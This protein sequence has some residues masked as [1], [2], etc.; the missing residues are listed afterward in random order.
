[1]L[2]FGILINHRF[3]SL[4]MD[5]TEKVKAFIDKKH[6]ESGGSCGTY[7]PDI[8]IETELEYDVLKPIL[9]Q[10]HNDKYFF[11]REGL[12]GKLIFKK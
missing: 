4:F 9:K 6:K 2:G 8:S 11:L 7:I 1:L 10:L 3:I 5:N 12:N